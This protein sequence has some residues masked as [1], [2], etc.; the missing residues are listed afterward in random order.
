MK[1]I[2]NQ[3]VPKVGK[4]GTVV[5]VAD[6][7][8]T[9]SSLDASLDFL[10]PIQIKR[11]V[12]ATPVSTV[13]AVDKLHIAADEIHILDVKDNFLGVNHYYNDNSVPSH[14]ETI[15]KINKIVLNWKK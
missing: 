12:V 10:K 6:G 15:A 3:T 5:L 1:V 13:Q 14:E 9:G 11:L 8:D 2:L 4:E 7:F